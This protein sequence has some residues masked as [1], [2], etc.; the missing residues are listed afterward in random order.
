MSNTVKLM[1]AG[2]MVPDNVTQ[3]LIRWKMLPEDFVSPDGSDSLDLGSPEA[4]IEALR[5]AIS[6]EAA[7]IRETEFDRIGAFRSATLVMDS[8][9]T[10]AI[11]AFVDRLNRVIVPARYDVSRL[12]AVQLDAGDLQ[13]VVRAEPRYEGDEQVAWVCYLEDYNAEKTTTHGRAPLS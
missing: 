9:P 3:Q 2:G 4:F 12:T 13:E 11:D 5:L 6:E 1:L 10:P 7:T 8:G